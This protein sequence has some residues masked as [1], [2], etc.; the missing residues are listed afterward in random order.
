MAISCSICNVGC[1]WPSSSSTNNTIERANG[2]F[3]V[4]MPRG[5][6]QATPACVSDSRAG[7]F[8][9][10]KIGVTRAIILILHR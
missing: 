8:W 10:G 5:K 9:R 1:C 2:M 6:V 3:G 4:D 7:K